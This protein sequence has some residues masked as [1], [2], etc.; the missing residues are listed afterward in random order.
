MRRRVWRID[1]TGANAVEGRVVWSPFKS[2]WHSLMYAIALGL[3]PVY[4]SW[5]AFALFL[6]SAYVTLLL[7][8]SL[9]MH[10]RL[11]HRSFECSKSFERF[12]VWLGVL[13]G[14]SGPFGI[15]KITRERTSRYNPRSRCIQTPIAFE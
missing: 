1:G 9:G 3:G 2:M 12:L 5:S 14:M 10:R 11:I 6:V 8:H 13:V 15:R 4:F 7:G